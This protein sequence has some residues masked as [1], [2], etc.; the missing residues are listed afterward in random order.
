MIEMKKKI[1][2]AE[3]ELVRAGIEQR[4]IWLYEFLKQAKE[5]GIDH[6]KFGRSVI[7]NCGCIKGEMKFSKTESLLEFTK[8]Y[9]PEAGQKAFDVEII[10]SSEDA[11][12]VESTY[13]PLVD[14]W[15]K[16]TDDEEFIK[17]LCDIAMDGDRGILSLYPEFKFEL[18][19]SLPSGDGMC[20]VEIY[21]VGGEN[22]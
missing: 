13:C 6:E 8:E 4:G 7:F 19:K 9:M 5:Q 17:E 22:D 20:R 15:Q 14:V 11:L 21:N 2:G 18:V 10:E 3:T 16:L 12:I 1:H